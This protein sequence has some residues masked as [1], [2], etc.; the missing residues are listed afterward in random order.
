MWAR[1][2]IWDEAWGEPVRAWI[3]SENIYG[4]T[5]GVFSSR[6]REFL[7]PYTLPPFPFV[8]TRIRLMDTYRPDQNPLDYVL[9]SNIFDDAERWAAHPLRSGYVMTHNLGFRDSYRWFL[10]FRVQ[11]QS[12]VACW[13]YKRVDR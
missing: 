4:S 11:S 13:V 10:D 3:K 5:I 1:D 2:V 7:V 9:V 12:C 8:H 6:Y